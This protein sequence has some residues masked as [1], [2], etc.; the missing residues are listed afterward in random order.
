M[1]KAQQGV[2]LEYLVLVEE[3]NS[4]LVNSLTAP[5]SRNVIVS[6]SPRPGIRSPV[7]DS[8]NVTSFVADLVEEEAEL[9]SNASSAVRLLEWCPSRFIFG[10]K[11]NA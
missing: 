2:V 1:T 6:N 5:V 11:R 4:L 3:V 9:V 7:L 8:V 10:A